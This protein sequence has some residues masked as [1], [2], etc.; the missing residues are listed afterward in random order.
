VDKIALVVDSTCDLPDAT[1]SQYV[2]AMVPLHVWI[3]GT[4]YLDR[5]E[6]DS[7]RFYKLFREADQGAKSSQPSVGEFMT[8]Y[9]DLLSRYEG[10]V[11]VH[12][13]A[14]L[15]GTVQTAAMA[16][17][18]VDAQ[19][20]RVVDSRHVSVGTGV[21]V[22][23]AGEAI[24]AGKDLDA[25]AAA[26]EAA[27]RETRVYGALPAL[28]VAVKGGRL[29]ARKARL[30][31]LIELKPL[32]VF[33]EEGGVHTDGA[34]L[35]YYRALRAVAERVARFAAGKPARVAVVHADGIEAA[36]YTEQRL[37]LL[38]GDIEIPIVE[39]GAVITT[40]VGLGTVSVAVQ[41]GHAAA[42]ATG[43]ASVVDVSRAS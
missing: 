37:R 6:L 8:V 38:L 7:T 1:R 22:Q 31:G 40:H 36:R 2:T 5:V 11:S 34:R 41:R 17:D 4:S 27:A 42:P 35:G 33:D 13:S 28:D 23:A 43:P 9:A 16:A 10:V 19:R 24:A 30:A 29:S 12:I 26:A 3:G 15:S 14:R 21:A 20:I 25:V 32:V 39:A 18:A